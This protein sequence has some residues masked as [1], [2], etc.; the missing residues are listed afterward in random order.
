VTLRL[1]FAGCKIG[2]Q[3]DRL[4]K[5][6]FKKEL[7]DQFATKIISQTKVFIYLITAEALPGNCEW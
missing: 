2:F 1:L 6:P 3:Q 5:R 7:A 4:Y